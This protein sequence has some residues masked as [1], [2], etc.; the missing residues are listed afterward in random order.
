MVERRCSLC[1]CLGG[2]IFRHGAMAESLDQCQL[3]EVVWTQPSLVNPFINPESLDR[4]PDA[5][6]CAFDAAFYN[7]SSLK[8][9]P[10]PG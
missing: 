2:Y 8:A 7:G 10:F 5:T 6:G 4:V 9:V 3:A 1:N